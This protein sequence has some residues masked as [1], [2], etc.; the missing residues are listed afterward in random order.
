MLYGRT[1]SRNSQSQQHSMHCVW[2][3][4]NEM[5]EN[6]VTVCYKTQ[7]YFKFKFKKKLARLVKKF[8]PVSVNS[9]SSK[10]NNRRKEEKK[11]TK[12]KKSRERY[13]NRRYQEKFR[14]YTENPERRAAI[15]L[16]SIELSNEELFA[17]ELGH[18]FVIAPNNPA[19]EEETLILEGFRFVDRL[20][21]ADSRLVELKKREGHVTSTQEGNIASQLS[22]L[23]VDENYYR[24]TEV[25]Y[26]LQ[27][28][29][30]KE[31]NL[32][33]NEAK[34]VK[35]EFEE[36]NGK[37]IESCRSKS[38][39][40]TFNIPRRTREALKHLQKLVKEKVIDIRKVDKGQLILVIDYNERKLIEQENID[41]IATLCT[42]QK[43]N[44]VDNK[45]YVENTMKSLLNHKF[46]TA[47]E[48]TAVTGLLAGGKDG[49]RKNRDGSIKFTNVLSS[50]ELFSKQVTPYVYPLLKAHKITM[51]ELL[52][53]KPDEIHSKL[54]SRLVVGMGS[55]QMNRV[56]VWLENL[57]SPLSIK[58]GAFEYIK[59]TTDYLLAL[60]DIKTKSQVENWDWNNIVMFTV[61]VKAL[62]PSV[63][64]DYLRKALHHVFNDLTSWSDD[65]KTYLVEL[66]LYT[67]EN[68]QICW[69]GKFF[70]LKQGLA[71]GAKHSVPLANIFLTF[72]I[73]EALK[74]CN[75]LNSLFES[76]VKLW[77]RFIDD[78]T[79][80][81]QGNIDEFLE[82]FQ[83]LQNEF[84]KFGLELTC[85]TDTHEVTEKNVHLKSKQFVP[86]LDLEVFKANGSIHTTEHR[87][88][89]SASSFL[90]IKSAHPKYTFPGIVKSQMIRLRRLCSRNTDF[91]DAIAKLKERCMNSGYCT[92]MVEGI[93]ANCNNLERNLLP[94]E[95]ADI[96]NK[97]CVRLVI[98]SGTV[99]ETELCNFARRMNN[100]LMSSELCVTVVKTT[101]L[102]LSRMLFNN[103]DKQIVDRHCSNQ[104]CIV[105]VND[106]RSELDHVTSNVTGHSYHI[107]ENINC[108][109]GGIYAVQGSCKDQYTGKTVTFSK[110]IS[111]HLTTDK[112]STVYGHKKDCHVCYHIKD[113]KITYLENYHT[114]GKYSLSEREYLWNH[115][116]K[117]TMNIHKTLKSK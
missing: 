64:F 70:M 77:K 40:R 113:F 106:L 81:F 23:S 20:G 51:S 95:N 96:D 103:N 8:E 18:G 42:D 15:N 67:L 117:G 49:K 61:D 97:L 86:F 60:E 11:A 59:D 62:Y 84:R 88:E 83:L 90:S 100:V 50:K 65:V 107:D 36:L 25:P 7:R 76:R 39:K 32:Q 72:I 111:E 10:V 6:N 116:L 46:I 31:V 104:R 108:D 91:I 102:S 79:G 58:Y 85:D 57:L 41:K 12:N 29:Q 78:A 13:M 38:K 99:Y 28:S 112:S 44:W 19:K 47:K 68:Q 109:N 16:S 53:L 98:L 54:P 80:I 87:K 45:S 35:I 24:S 74:N 48:L 105:C 37:L 82:F 66:I 26:M 4:L 56:Q 30:P 73:L 22:S 3:K 33:T 115:R 34:M 93:L 52:K 101:Y 27:F 17:L 89:T 63:K 110:R 69:N 21:K 94:K 1:N 92:K 55:C 2:I 71:T 43:S 5:K 14:A 75:Q 9:S 114:R